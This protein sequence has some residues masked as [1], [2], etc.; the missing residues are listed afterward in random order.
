VQVQVQVFACLYA[1][2][3]TDMH[4]CEAGDIRCALLWPEEG[5]GGKFV[6]RSLSDVCSCL[7][8]LNFGLDPKQWR[9]EMDTAFIT[10]G[11]LL[12]CG[13]SKRLREWE[14]ESEGW[15]SSR[16]RESQREPERAR[17]RTCD[18][19]K[20]APLFVACATNQ[21]VGERA[22]GRKCVRAHD[23][24]WTSLVSGRRCILRAVA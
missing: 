3:R 1:R 15:E 23:L 24:K 22:R 17:A 4:S 5:T 13:K 12:L 20:G 11:S 6:C 2:A 18:Q 8:E 10:M 14:R 19:D 21:L 7:S 9:L 16:D